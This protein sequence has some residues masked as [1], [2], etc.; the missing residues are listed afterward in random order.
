MNIYKIN[1]I[2]ELGQDTAA[3]VGMF[4]GVHIG[5]Q[6]ILALLRQE[7]ERLNLTPVVVTFGQHPRQ[8]LGG[9][10]GGVGVDRFYRITTNSERYALLEHFGI[11]HVLELNFT[12]QT[13]D[14]SACQFF[15]QILLGR[16]RVKALVLGYDNMFGSKQHNDFDRLPAL[17]QSYGVGV[18]VD[19][20]VQR[21]GIEVSSTQVRKALKR[22]DVS[23]A[24]EL[25]GYNY[26]LWGL[27]VQGR[28]MGRRLG[29][30]T[31]NVC[32]DDTTKVMPADGVYAVRI[33]LENS[34]IPRIGM[35]NFGGQP[36]FGLDKPVFEVNIFDFDGDLY[37]TTLRVEFVSRLRDVQKF[38]SVHELA[39]QLN[40]DR[41]EARRGLEARSG[42]GI[43]FFLARTE[44]VQE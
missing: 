40:A 21:C 20:A 26:R 30:P 33:Y 34:T 17:A 41:D 2:S 28:Q 29:F 36:T 1:N 12:R 19:T 5:H 9:G 42:Q 14:L 25:L 11:H 24:A 44:P 8:V 39:C 7:A 43:D 23:L 10:V 38:D 37:G 13:A 22:G 4:D 6:H 35:A 3:T 16:L 15:E 27:V 18:K 31:A 32:L